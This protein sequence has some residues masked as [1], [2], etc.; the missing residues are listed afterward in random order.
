MREYGRVIIDIAYG[1]V[2]ERGIDEYAVARLHGQ[3]DPVVGGVGH[4]DRLLDGDLARVRIDGEQSHLV[5]AH[6]NVRYLGRL[7]LI[8][9][10]H[11]ELGLEL[12]GAFVDHRAILVLQETRRT[13]VRI[14]QADA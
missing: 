13:V 4:V 7:V 6:Q 8:A 12:L 11:L 9:R 14:Y 2:D 3:V 5:A 1:D 10:Q